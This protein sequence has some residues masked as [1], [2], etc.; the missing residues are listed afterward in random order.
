MNS[1]LIRRLGRVGVLMGGWSAEREVSLQSGATVLE[2]LRALGVEAEGVDLRRDTAVEQI[3]AGG[4]D[5]C[6]IV[7]HGT[8]GEDGTLQALL[9][10]LGLPY[11]GSGVLGSALGMDKW[12]C[13]L[14]WQAQGL[15]VVP[16]EVLHE[17]DDYEA[18][19]ERLGLPLFVK[20]SQEGSS[21]GVSR[22]ERAEDLPQAYA[23]AAACH[24]QVLVEPAM[25]GGDYTVAVLAGEALP[26][27]RIQPANGF[28]DYAA[29]YLREDTRYLCPCGLPPAVQ[30]RL[31]ELALA[32]FRAVDGR[33][34][35]RV[36]F[37]FDDAGEP[38]LAEVNTVPGMTPHSLVPMAARAAGMDLQ[39]L[40]WRIL[41]A[42]LTHEP[43]NEA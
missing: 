43:R 38:R 14:L 34:W 25:P 32:A 29:K 15:P 23:V 5:R 2:A 20:P 26:A 6:F 42:S 21:V 24:G 35:G 37:L 9:E 1:E 4:F 33:G 30:R 40:V 41:E 36:D 19:V 13:K 17:G 22:V 28:Y 16:G 12:R 7:V 8:G 39:T 3:L 31:G 27:I 11:T 10:M 18:V